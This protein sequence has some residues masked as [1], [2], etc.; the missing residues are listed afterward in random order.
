MR[1][2]T[3]RWV[4]GRTLQDIQADSAET[5]NVG[6]VDLGEEADFGRCHGIVVG[7]EQFQLEDTTWK[8]RGG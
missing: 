5:V 3:Q 2:Y 1:L 6:V 8:A 7:Q 4:I